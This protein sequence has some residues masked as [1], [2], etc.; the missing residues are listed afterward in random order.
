[1]KIQFC[2]FNIPEKT[3]SDLIFDAAGIG[4]NGGLTVSGFLW[5]LINTPDIQL[6]AVIVIVSIFLG[7]FVSDF[8]SGAFH[9]AFD[10]W[11]DEQHSWF[12]R[13]VLIVREHHIYP[14]NIFRYTFLE[15]CGPVSWASFAITIPL[16]LV[17][18][19]IP[20]TASVRWCIVCVCIIISVCM[21][22]MLQLHKLGH[23]Y[24]RLW[25]VRVLQRFRVVMSPSHHCIHHNG[26]HDRNYCIVNG[27]ADQFCDTLGIW[28]CAER[29]VTRLTGLAPRANDHKW[30]S[31]YGRTSTA[32]GA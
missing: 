13:M 25:Y 18:F 30:M 20:G 9:W 2:K 3:R 10:T 32:D 24:S 15:E 29:L 6:N 1:M 27:W 4:L 23:G 5:L 7:I 14:N 16:Y 8:L 19:L 22:L 28:R 11:F 21:T 17:A 31:R 12:K 26:R